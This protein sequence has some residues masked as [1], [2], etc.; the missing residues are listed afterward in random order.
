MASQNSIKLFQFFQRYCEAIGMEVPQSNENRFKL[1]AMS[2]F[3]IFSLIEY[4]IAS[5][6]F[7]L[8]DANSMSEYG[9]TFV[10]LC[11]DGIV[12]IVYSVMIWQLK[13][14]SNYIEFCERFIEMSK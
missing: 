2:L 9:M 4:W 3:F 5:A 11:C 10:I 6:A 7:M 14:I 1:N 8:F 12:I 13:D